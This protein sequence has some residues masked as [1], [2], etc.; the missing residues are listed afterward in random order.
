MLETAFRHF[1]YQYT[2][3]VFLSSPHVS[4]FPHHPHLPRSPNHSCH[5]PPSSLPRSIL[6]VTPTIL[7]SLISLAKSHKSQTP[8]TEEGHCLFQII[9]AASS[10]PPMIILLPPFFA[11]LAFHLRHHYQWYCSPFS[12]SWLSPIWCF[13]SYII[14]QVIWMMYIIHYSASNRDD[15]EII[16]W[17]DPNP[18]TLLEAVEDVRPR[19]VNKKVLMLTLSLRENS[20]ENYRNVRKDERI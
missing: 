9:L 13:T 19:N 7:L 2:R 17:R 16:W 4:Y 10:S 11:N 5:P 1:K 8:G 3:Q 20:S 12:L 18:Y 15:V 6:L 14:P